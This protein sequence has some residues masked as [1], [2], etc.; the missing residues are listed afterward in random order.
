MMQ[1]I[2]MKICLTVA[3]LGV[4]PVKTLPCIDCVILGQN[5]LHQVDPLITAYIYSLA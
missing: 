2:T 4:L 3:L 1:K 5:P